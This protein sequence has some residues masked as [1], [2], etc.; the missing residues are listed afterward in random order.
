[1]SRTRSEWARMARFV[2]MAVTLAAAAPSFAQLTKDDAGL[3]AGPGAMVEYTITKPASPET[4]PNTVFGSFLE[5]IG[6]STYGG[7]WADVVENPSFES[8]LWSAERI[9]AMVQDQPE[10]RRASQL[11]LPLPWL[12]LEMDQGNRYLPERARP[13]APVPNSDEALEV[14]GLPDTQV[15]IRQRVYL[16]VHRELE[17]AGSLWVKHVRGD[18]GVRV[19][20]RRHDHPETV[21]AEAVLSAPKAAWTR[22]AF[23]L[24]LPRGAVAPLAP[25]DLVIALDG[26]AR[27]EFDNV[28]LFPADA[29]DGMD[30][31]VIAMAKALHSPLIRFGG[32]FTSGYDWRDGVGPEDKRISMRNVSWGIP[33]YNT[34]GTDEFL[35]FCRQIDAQPQVA[36][37]LG[38]GTPGQAADWVRYIDKQWGHA[39]LLWELGNELWGN[40]QIGYPTEPQ[41]GEVTAATSRA[42]RA[43][44]PTSRL[45]ATGADPDHFASWDAVQLK[46]PAGTFG[47]L[48]THFVV[49][50]R[51]MMAHPA[52]DFSTMAALALPVGL[53]ERL[54]AI[55]AQAQAADR[56]AVK[57]AFTEWLMVSHDGTGPNFDNMG[58]ALFTGGFLNMILR[59]VDVVP[60]S[61]MTGI[62]EFAGIW[63]RKGQVYASPA[64]YVLRDYATEAPKTLLDARMTAGPAYS[65]TQGNERIPEIKDVPYLDVTAALSADG[66]RL[67]LFCVNRHLTEGM[68]AKFDLSA[69]GVRAGARATLHV[70]EADSIRSRNSAERPDAVV[71]EDSTEAVQAEWA[72]T[73]PAASVTVVSV[74][75]G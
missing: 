55:R 19:S 8:G 35:E 38:S 63:Q 71:P 25:V 37:N 23:R 12:P 43:V 66:R 51:V 33:E 54:H 72:H 40:W 50:D 56:P 4:I 69:L 30:P 32:N 14:M 10:L 6:S 46:Q 1:M 26:D 53:A 28:H 62:M 3:K 49:G 57:V 39:G 61:D 74:P 29:I 65:V 17:Y 52:P 24:T 16:P 2:T 70:L 9:A 15:G 64:Y 20:L 27:A 22:L 45:I 36:L 58:G 18:A 59:N 48:S 47:Y 68:A 11:G 13:D 31:D 7:L 75:L 67:L 41:I 44:D 21:L 60:I 42:V 5:P 73:F 34:F